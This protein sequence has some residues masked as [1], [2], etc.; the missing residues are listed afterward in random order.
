MIQT[1]TQNDVILIADPSILSIP[2]IENH[3]PLIDLRDKEGII[4]G[5]SPEIPH[6]TDYTKMRKTVYEMLIE[7]QKQLPK[8]LRLCVY[9]GY[10]SIKLQEKLFNGYY[11]KMQEKHT[12]WNH[13]QIFQETTKLVSPVVNLDGSH[14]VPPHSTGAAVDVYLVDEE[15]KPIEMGILTKDW[16]DDLDGSISMTAS[17]KISKEAKA[18]REIMNHVLRDVGFINY[19]TEYW[20]WSYGDRYWA[21]HKS[22]QNALYGSV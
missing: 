13:E 2:I 4:F 9:E 3:E 21:H 22:K 6:N 7:A 12:L 5:S 18:N 17:E 8:S 14:N 1:S 16:T 19:P 20:H 10:R 15:G 11:D